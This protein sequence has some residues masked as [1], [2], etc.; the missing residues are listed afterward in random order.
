M[1]AEIKAKNANQESIAMARR[2][3]AVV[4][5]PAPIKAGA[6]HGKISPRPALG[7]E[8]YDP[9][10][11]SAH[12]LA[13]VQRSLTIKVRRFLGFQTQNACPFES[14]FRSI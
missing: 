5:R 14:S 13:P 10:V 8:V 1:I 9:R 3:R 2:S 12:A 7:M 6:N 11:V 4:I